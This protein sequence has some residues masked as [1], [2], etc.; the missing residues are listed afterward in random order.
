MERFYPYGYFCNRYGMWC[1]DVVDV[2]EGHNDCNGD[3]LEC[4]ECEKVESQY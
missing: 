4:E 3:C 1:D 2:T